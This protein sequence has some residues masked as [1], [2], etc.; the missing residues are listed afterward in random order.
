MHLCGRTWP[1]SQENVDRLIP[2]EAGEAHGSMRYVLCAR[3][4]VGQ[5]KKHLLVH[6]SHQLDAGLYNVSE[7]FEFYY[8]KRSRLL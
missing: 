1:F 7:F 8:S 4:H 5:T 3:P 6:P 2:K